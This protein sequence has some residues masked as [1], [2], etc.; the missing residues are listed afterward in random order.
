MARVAV[1]GTGL[2][3]APIARN[4]AAAGHDVVVWN[5]TREKAEATGLPVAGS[6][7]EAV[8]GAD[9]VVTMVAD[10]PA[11]E[12]VIDD[13]AL[14]TFGDGAVWIQSSTVGLGVERVHARAREHGVAFVDAPVSGTRLPAERGELL[15]LASGPEGLRPRCEPV[16]A[17]IASRTLWLGDVGAGSR[18]KLVLNAWLLGLLEALAETLTLTEALG[19]EPG[20]FLDTIAG[21]PLDFGYAQLKGGMMIARDYPPA[22]P[23]RLALKDGRLIQE[24]AASAGLQLPGVQ[25]AADQLT[26]ALDAGL[27]DDDMAAVREALRGAG[28]R[29]GDG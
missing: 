20:L 4:V 16:F 13:A 18:L 21:G 19:L 25:A 9:L 22:F 23:L 6:P 5:R 26:R 14:G 24:A 7:L 29:P 28:A 1:L 15:V 17:A 3:G 27:G 12:S 2:M 10:L 11:V 8:H